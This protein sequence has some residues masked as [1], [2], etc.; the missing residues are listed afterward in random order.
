MKELKDSRLLRVLFIITIIA[1]I[2]IL[3][4]KST[5]VKNTV[6][7]QLSDK[8]P[9]QM[10]GYIIKTE[11]DKLIVIDGGTLDDTDNLV[12]QICKNGGKVDYWFIT[13]A[14]DDHAG[15]FTKVVNDTKIPIENVY[16]SLNDLQWYEENDA[17]RIEFIRGL[18]DIVQ[19]SR[20][21]NVVISPNIND[22]LIID[23]IEV[24]VLGIRNPEI[25]ENAGNEQSM[26]LKFIA[27]NKS[28]LILGDTGIRSSEKLLMT[29]G[30]KLKSDMVQMAH[31]GQNGATKELYSRINP[32]I[33]L[34]PTPKW[35]WD[36]DA[37]EGYNTGEWLTI[38]TRTWME[39]LGVKENYIEKDGDI[40]IIWK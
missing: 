37:G 8:G 34:W 14:H 33:C 15:A 11:N 10:M 27:N 18:F 22:K 6:L 28:L 19:N 36:N 25:T 1:L 12:S 21:S 31:H 20:I 30:D 32:E 5:E 26:V 2:I 38:E 3:Y 4:F 29:Q 39:E 35:L 40:K 9:R 24:E 16:I 13:H 23:N 17:T 7:I